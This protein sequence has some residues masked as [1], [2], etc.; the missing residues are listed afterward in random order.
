[1]NDPN[2]YYKNIIVYIT[3]RTED[4]VMFIWL[5]S[6]LPGR[7]TI[8]RSSQFPFNLIEPDRCYAILTRTPQNSGRGASWDWVT[9]YPLVM[10]E[11]I[12]TP[13]DV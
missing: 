11:V 13:E 8:P 12:E 7:L 3:E 5:D 6:R 9:A 10:S 4:A 2:F 1:M